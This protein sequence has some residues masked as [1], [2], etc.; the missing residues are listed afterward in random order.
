[1]PLIDISSSPR[2]LHYSFSSLARDYTIRLGLSKVKSMGA[3]A[4]RFLLFRSA[5]I[6]LKIVHAPNSGGEPGA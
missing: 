6:L 4:L 3:T 2:L 1:M 5:L